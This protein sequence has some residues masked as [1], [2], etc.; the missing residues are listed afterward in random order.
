MDII[1]A[2]ASPRRREI[3]EMFNLKFDVNPSNIDENIDIKNPYEFVESLSYNKAKNIADKNSDSL[4]I[5]CDTIV[6]INDRILGKPVDEKDALNMLK[7]LSGKVHEV[8]TGISLVCKNKNI[9]L[10]SHE[11]TKVYFKDL[12]DEEILCYIKTKEPLD[13]AGSYGIQGL[14]SVFVEKIDGCYFNV[15]GLPTSKLYTLL[16]RIGVNLLGRK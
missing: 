5:G 1:L 16:G 15:V 11:T 7:L 14:A 6:H 12:S 9:K 3:L 8:V 2:S 13:K 4:V 10:I